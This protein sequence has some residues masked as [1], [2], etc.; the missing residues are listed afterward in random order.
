ML[1]RIH[2]LYLRYAAV[3]AGRLRSVPLG[4]FWRRTGQIAR[5]VRRGDKVEISGWANADSLTLRWS[6]APGCQNQ[7]ATGAI[8]QLGQST[9]NLI[10]FIW[11]QAS[12]S[13][14]GLPRRCS[15]YVL[16]ARDDCS[17]VGVMD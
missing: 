6:G 5:V 13:P 15:A 2:A 7:M 12:L 17:P 8:N 1:R 14:F 3:H 4:P 9:L 10:L 11:N 16:T